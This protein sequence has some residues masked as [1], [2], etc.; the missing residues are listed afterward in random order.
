MSL[1][2]HKGTQK[3]RL[4]TYS[5]F[6][7]KLYGFCDR[8]SI[9]HPSLHFVENGIFTPIGSLLSAEHNGGFN[10]A[11]DCAVAKLRL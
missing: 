8:L 7:V 11:I 1:A 9:K 5:V 2:D 10:F 6:V 4:G 3:G